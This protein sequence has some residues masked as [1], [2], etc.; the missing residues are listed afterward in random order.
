MISEISKYQ[1]IIFGTSI[2]AQ[3]LIKTIS[4]TKKI[5][6]VDGGSE[7][8]KPE[9]EALTDNDEYGH[10]SNGWWK[11][12]WVRA[13]G[14]TSRRWSGWIAALDDRDF[15]G[16]NELPKWPIKKDDLE[17]YYKLAANF[18]ERDSSI[19]N[20]AQKTNLN[21]E[22][23][24]KPFSNGSPKRFLDIKDLKKYPNV[25]LLLNTNLIRLTSNDRKSIDGLVIFQNGKEEL[26]AITPNQKVIL[27]CGGLGNAQILLQPAARSAVSIGNES[28]L[29]GKFLMEHP[30]AHSADILIDKSKLPKVNDTFG[31][32]TRAFTP[33]THVLQKH[34]LLNCTVAIEDLPKENRIASKEQNYFER[35][36]GAKLERVIGYARGEQEPLLNNQ[37]VI[38]NKKNWAGLY[39]LRTQCAF[40]NRD[41]YTLDLTTRL[42]G[43]YIFQNKIGILKIKNDNIYRNSGGGGHT[44]GTTRMGFSIKDS[45]CDKNHKV[46]S[47]NNLYIVG[48]SIFPTVGS[49][50]P[51]LTISATSMRLGQ[52]LNR[53]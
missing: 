1:I 29:A 48:S 46:H 38:V 42:F 12:H 2:A 52:I 34:G 47:Y 11:R 32:H 18:L 15:I 7:S 5:L 40:S 25:D 41:L 27:A 8:E 16:L 43:E 28:G 49:A 24:F 33:S 36:W 10:L 37:V 26:V 50:N 35:L 30:H 20:F 17:Q 6:L 14:G 4:P 22:F 45:V 9:N 3:S 23:I 51:T 21:D 19:L 39:T 44:M 53:A 31:Y 13:Y